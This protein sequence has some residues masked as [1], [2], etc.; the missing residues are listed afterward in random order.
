PAAAASKV[1]APIG[2]P[3]AGASGSNTDNTGSTSAGDS[4]GATTL[5]PLGFAKIGDLTAE[6]LVAGVPGSI[7]VPI[8]DPLLVPLTNIKAVLTIDGKTPQ[9]QSVQMLLPQQ[10]RSIVFSNVVIAESGA[11]QARV[12]VQLLRAGKSQLGTVAQT[13]IVQ[14]A[15][16]PGMTT[17]KP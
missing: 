7:L 8:S 10:S 5:A 2:S 17:A 12:G 14:P 3:V 6:H 16:N 15:T 11:H 1:R 9:T 4:T 13:I